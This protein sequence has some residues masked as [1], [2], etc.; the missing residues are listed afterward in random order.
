MSNRQISGNRRWTWPILWAAALLVTVPCGT[1]SAGAGPLGSA[2]APAAAHT[3]MLRMVALRIPSERSRQKA[4]TRL[5]KA[6]AS[7]ETSPGPLDTRALRLGRDADDPAPEFLT[8]AEVQRCV[9]L[10]SLTELAAWDDYPPAIKD[11]LRFSANPNL[12]VLMPEEE[13]YYLARALH[14]GLT[15]PDLRARYARRGSALPAG[16]RKKLDAAAGQLSGG[17]TVLPLWSCAS[18]FLRFIKT[19]T[20]PRR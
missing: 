18:A 2:L 14:H 16:L 19:R 17:G 11:L 5:R 10:S 4:L 20:A 7:Q 8:Y 3:G 6:L 15:V 12:L 9:A 13:Y 1:T